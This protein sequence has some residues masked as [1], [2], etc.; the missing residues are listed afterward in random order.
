MYM[1]GTKLTPVATELVKS[2]DEIP[3]PINWGPCVDVA[4]LARPRP[5]L[6]IQPGWMFG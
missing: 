6:D 3:L 5:V 4:L 2:D 1:F